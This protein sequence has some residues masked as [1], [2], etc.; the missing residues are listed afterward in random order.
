MGPEQ[1]QQKRDFFLRTDLNHGFLPF[2]PLVGASGEGVQDDL[3]SGMFQT[4]FV[5]RASRI[6]PN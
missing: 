1:R 4:C 5:R 6:S 3:V 2:A